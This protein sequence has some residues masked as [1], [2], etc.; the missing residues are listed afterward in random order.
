MNTTEK[1]EVSQEMLWCQDI[2]GYT[3]SALRRIFPNTVFN[4]GAAGTMGACAGLI[5]GLKLAGKEEMAQS[6]AKTL[7]RSFQFGMNDAREKQ[8]EY[9]WREPYRQI[10]A[11]SSDGC[12]FSFGFCLY[13][14]LEDQESTND[15][16]VKFPVYEGCEFKYGR[17]FNGGIICHG[18]GNQ[19]YAVSFGNDSGFP[20]WSMHT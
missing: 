20:H 15:R 11:V 4:D 1:Q 6:M 12:P 7:F 2:V 16:V 9:H 13:T 8:G 17:N 5:I 19:T 18:L 10:L 3:D 14:I